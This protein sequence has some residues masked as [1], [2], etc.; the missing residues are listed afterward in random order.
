ML[1]CNNLF[2]FSRKK[3][4]HRTLIPN[5]NCKTVSYETCQFYQQSF[6]RCMARERNAFINQTT[7]AAI[8]V[9]CAWHSITKKIRTKKKRA[10]ELK[11]R[12]N[13]Y[14]LAN[15][16]AWIYIKLFA[17][18]SHS[19]PQQCLRCEASAEE[20]QK[21]ISR[22]EKKTEREK[23]FTTTKNYARTIANGYFVYDNSL[24]F[25]HFVSHTLA[26]THSF[27]ACVSSVPCATLSKNCL[28][29]PRSFA[30][31]SQQRVDLCLI[32]FLPTTSKALYYLALSRFE[33]RHKHTLT[34]RHCSQWLSNAIPFHQN[35]QFS[36]K[37]H[38]D[39]VSKTEEQQN[40]HTHTS[41]LPSRNATLQF[42]CAT[43]NGELSTLFFSC[44]YHFPSKND[45]NYRHFR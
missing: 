31:W 24:I 15:R 37:K 19:W 11:I 13:C 44:L 27:F 21:H 45:A 2:D 35:T 30:I 17:K 29:A 41:Q 5:A 20:Q 12:M 8:C 22:A 14:R 42:I 28:F 26:F 32:A 36:G 43:A 6:N 1:H 39:P 38:T 18:C 9:P 23:L 25:V 3:N 40:T 4:E 7:G 16:W 34:I 33:Q 10:R